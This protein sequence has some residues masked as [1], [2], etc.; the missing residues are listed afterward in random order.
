[1]SE[2]TDKLIDE[3]FKSVTP[4]LSTWRIAAFSISAML[5]SPEF[6][7]SALKTLF[8]GATSESAKNFGK[9]VLAVPLWQLLALSFAWFVVVPKISNL[10]IMLMVERIHIKKSEKLIDIL[11]SIRQR[12]PGSVASEFNDGLPILYKSRKAAGIF[13]RR[14]K[15]AAEIDVGIAGVAIYYLL[16]YWRG[17]FSALILLACIISIYKISQKILI[18]YLSKVALYQAVIGALE[19]VGTVAKVRRDYT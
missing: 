8:V 3:T 10:L 16:G 2:I 9:Y 13:I 19:Q 15:L 5:L 1:M 4:L 14:L 11:I 7:R 18:E 17:L 6:S 12:D